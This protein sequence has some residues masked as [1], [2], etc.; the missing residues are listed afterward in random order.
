MAHQHNNKSR[1]SFLGSSYTTLSIFLVISLV[2]CWINSLITI[3]ALPLGIVSFELM[4]TQE[5]AFI[6]LQSLSHIQLQLLIFSLGLDFLYIYT[7]VFLLKIWL[8][9]LE[10]SSRKIGLGLISLVMLDSIE[11]VGLLHLLLTE[12]TQHTMLISISATAKF[13]II[14]SM[15][16]WAATTQ[17]RKQDA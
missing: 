14:L 15:I 12:D 13:I 3:D 7:Y 10:M 8:D 17:F 1:P 2:F 4:W 16:A 11:N 9:R 5:Q 6:V